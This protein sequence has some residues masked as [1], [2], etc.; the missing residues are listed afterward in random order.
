MKEC[1]TKD[2]EFKNSFAVFMCTSYK[3]TVDSFHMSLALKCGSL[4]LTLAL[5]SCWKAQLKSHGGSPTP[6]PNISLTMDN[7]KF[8]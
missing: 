1:G 5:L 3:Y 8:N 2:E 4:V 7:V 6:I